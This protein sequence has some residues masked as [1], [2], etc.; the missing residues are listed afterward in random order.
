MGYLSRSIVGVAENMNPYSRSEDLRLY[1]CVGKSDMKYHNAFQGS[2]IKGNHTAKDSERLCPP[3]MSQLES[4]TK[5]GF[6]VMLTGPRGSGKTT[7]VHMVA[8]KLGKQLTT[9]AGH[10]DA[11]IEDLRGAMGLRDGNTSFTPGSVTR[12]VKE[13]NYL[14]FDEVNLC[15]PNVTAWLNN[16]IDENGVFTIPET[17]EEV[18]VPNDFLCFFCFNEGYSGTRDLNEALVDRCRVIYCDYWPAEMEFKL[19]KKRYPEFSD[20]D[21]RRVI[22]VANAIRRAQSE[23]SV[24]F[25]FSVRTLMHWLSDAYIRT[26]DLLESYREV[27]LPKVGD[28]RLFAP[29]HEALMEIA[30]LTLDDE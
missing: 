4:A 30:R 17:G 21:I 11:G 1:D 24:D 25:D 15:R 27:V 13:N 18:R 3:F 8:K 26:V 28:P 12:A 19:L 7:A 2:N 10:A 16:V 20:I 23:G 9:V 5:S 6:N 29:Q 14:L 22:S